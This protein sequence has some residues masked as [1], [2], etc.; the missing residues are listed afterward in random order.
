MS[1]KDLKEELLRKKKEAEEAAHVDDWVT[2]PTHYRTDIDGNFI[3]K[4]DGTPHKKK[5][6]HRERPNPKKKAKAASKQ[7]IKDADKKIAKL[8][9][10]IKNAKLRK[11]NNTETLKK[12]DGTA[13]NR[14]TL[15]EELNDLPQEVRY[16]LE[17]EETSVAFK[18]NPGPQEEFLAAGEKDVL[19]GGAAGGGK[20]YAL[21]VDPLR[22]CHL[23][24]AR[25]LLIRRTMPELRELIDKSYELFPKAF[26]GCKFKQQEKIWTFPSGAK[27]EFGYCEK[28]SDVYR[29]QG[30]AY[31]WIGFDELTQ[32]PSSFCWDYLAT[33]LRT[34]NPEI[35]P[36]LRATANP[37][38][39]GGNW[40]KA[41][42]IDP[43][44]PNESFIGEK[45][46]MSR[47]FIP[48]LLKD[49][50]YLH[51]N[52]DYESILKGMPDVLRK[53]LLEGDWNV[54]EG[55]AFPEFDKTLGHHV[56]SPFEIPAHWE[57]VKGIDYGFAAPS[58][59]MWA[60]VDPED[61]TLIIYRELYKKGLTGSELSAIITEM[62]RDEMR[63]IPGVLDTAAWAQ[64]G[65]AYRGP[66]IGEV[67][68]N[69]GHK[70]RR[71]DKNRIAGKVQFHERLRVDR[72]TG[73][74]KMQIFS[75]CPNIIN[76][77]QSL[78]TDKSKP[79]DVD[80]HAEDHAYDALRYLIM[81]RPRLEGHSSRM[82][83]FKSEVFQPSDNIFGY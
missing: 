42:Y 80:T 61:G 17:R 11:K 24:D 64:A 33:R 79:E 2:N 40:V 51:L 57:R 15:K 44:P 36:Y 28:D 30:Q 68:V 14:V 3:L 82:A 7:R 67:L 62:E 58:A 21:L 16:Q 46:N 66:T 4:K 41:R 22:F 8:Q 26:P 76:E 50:P 29:Y 52:G 1:I 83:R 49:N 45:D 75:S 43:C 47:K 70:L 37:G 20:S 48:A 5:M 31:S 12:I 55:A 73:R 65:G 56:I 34:T 9:K 18:A 60:A 6:V 39:V 38:N 13:S 32:W 63:S 19:Y 23:A 59:C 25:A 54:T 77:L 27:L 81:S 71:A 78:P 10:E 35:T 53:Q 74:P 72:N 69:S